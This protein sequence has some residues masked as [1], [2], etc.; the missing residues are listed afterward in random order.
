M[1][2][3]LLLPSGAPTCTEDKHVSHT[4]QVEPTLILPALR[5][6][7]IG[8][9]SHSIKIRWPTNMCTFHLSQMTASLTISNLRK[10][11]YGR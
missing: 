10:K 2:S 1:F 5:P 6:E 11:P 4:H 9:H 8:M 7:V 3:S